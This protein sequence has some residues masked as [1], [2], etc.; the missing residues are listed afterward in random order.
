M[1]ETGIDSLSKANKS[2][3]FLSQ[4]LVK[5]FMRVSNGALSFPAQ[6]QVGSYS[7]GMALTRNVGTPAFATSAD[8][9]SADVS[10]HTQA[11]DKLA[12]VCLV[13]PP[14]VSQAIL[15]E[16]RGQQGL[17]FLTEHCSPRHVHGG[18]GTSSGNM[19]SSTLC[20]LLG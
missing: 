7:R 19:T 10:E 12:Y 9:G 1:A 8:Y 6:P 18:F 3:L 20:Q 15:C 13:L 16:R 11:S 14:S 17:E 5:L 4:L 2:A